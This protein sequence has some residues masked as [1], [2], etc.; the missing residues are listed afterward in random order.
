MTIDTLPVSVGFQEQVAYVNN[1]RHF[2]CRCLYCKQQHPAPMYVINS[3]AT[4]VVATE[5][6]NI[7]LF[8]C[9]NKKQIL[10]LNML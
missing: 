3:L 5:I 1:T 10:Q 8:V 6:K 4:Q 9:I 7:M 2:G